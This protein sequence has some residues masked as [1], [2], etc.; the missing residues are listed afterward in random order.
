MDPTATYTAFVSALVDEEYSAAFE[1]AVSL[2]DWLRAD[3]FGPSQWVDTPALRTFF[4]MFRS[5]AY[6]VVTTGRDIVRANVA[7]SVQ[8]SREAR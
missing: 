1:L 7:R 6:A 5:F 8:L 4:Y 2:D 3:G